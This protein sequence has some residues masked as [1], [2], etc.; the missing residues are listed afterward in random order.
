M[1]SP[2]QRRRQGS[3]GAEGKVFNQRFVKESHFIGR[4]RLEDFEPSGDGIPF[5]GWILRAAALNSVEENI[6]RSREIVQLDGSAEGSGSEPQIIPFGP[7]PS[8]PFDDYG[9]AEREEFLTE[10]PLQGFDLPA[11]VFIV[12]IECKSVHPLVGGKANRTEPAFK[13]PGEG[14]L[15]CTRQPAYNDQSRSTAGSF[16]G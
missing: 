4:R 16:H 12:D 10:S 5:N 7:S 13:H 15:T 2:T 14:G 6:G 3:V 9:E 8:A 11:P 1:A